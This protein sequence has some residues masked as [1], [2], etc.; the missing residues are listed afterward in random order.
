M[1]VERR[2]GLQ[3]VERLLKQGKLQAALGELRKVS[4]NAPNDLLTLNRL[5]D[6]LARQ[7]R[8][9]EAVAYYNK[10][11]AQFAGGGFVPKA[12]AIHKKILRLDPQNLESI[13]RLGELYIQQNLHGEARNY[14]LHAANQYLQSQQF[15][16]ARRIY[17][18]LVEV[19]PTD[20]R[21]RVRLAEAS[22]A[23]GNPRAAC[24]ALTD[25][26]RSLLDSGKAQEAEKLY[27]RAAELMPGSHVPLLGVASCLSEQG[28]AADGLALLEKAAGEANASPALVGDLVLRYD[29][30]GR[31]EEALALLLKLPVFEVPQ[32][33]WQ[34]LFGKYLIRGQVDRL[35]QRLDP[36]FQAAVPANDPQPLAQLLEQL[37]ELEAEGHVPALQRLLELQRRRHE[38]Q[39]TVQAL[40]WLVRA[41]QARSMHDEASLMLDEL[42]E[43]APDSPLVSTDPEVLRAYEERAAASASSSAPA[44]VV[45][46]V[47]SEAEAPAVPL[48]RADEEF[49][50]GRMT[51]AEVLEKYGLRPQALEQLQEVVSRFPGHVRAQEMRLKMLRSG[52]DKQ[53]LSGALVQFALALRADGDVQGARH[54][55]EEAGS[56]VTLDATTRSTLE[57]LKLVEPAARPAVAAAA[58]AVAAPEMV[59]GL[60]EPPSARPAPRERA[61]LVDDGDADVEIIEIDDEADVDAAAEAEE[62]EPVVAA[63]TATP[64]RPSSRRPTRVPSPDM[65]EEIERY[66]T[67]GDTQAALGRIDALR[68]L[69]YASPELDALAGRVSRAAPPAAAPIVPPATAT[70]Q[71]PEIEDPSA[72]LGLDDDD[73]LRAI[74][75]ALEHELFDGGSEPIVPEEDPEQS[76]DEIFATFKAQVQ[77]EVD[78]DDYRTHYDLGIAYKEMGLVDEAISEFEIASKCTS[79]Y[80]EACVMVALCHRERVDMAAAARWYRQALEAPGGEPEMLNRVRYELA[81]VLLE[82]GDGAG[83]LGLFRDVLQADPAYRDVRGRVTQLEADLR[84]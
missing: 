10:I 4:E 47:S 14:L 64:E 77:Q 2:K 63:R 70:A 17:E 27:R 48:N 3:T 53:R 38:T 61:V 32:H 13:V 8:N 29:A 59:V 7:G 67:T 11:A 43:L 76:L 57:Q 41:Y 65:L 46:D 79:L 36:V 34:G 18:R 73:D 44:P 26:G 56:L 49:V 78:S 74:T 40:E 30:V 54:A 16:R 60:E 50:A 33:V 20:F 68:L 24:D 28:R 39:G 71:E 83:A 58:A 69:G 21:H 22:A 84:S 19:D 72:A 42:R 55:A 37:G 62:R 25:L 81:E 35:W 75:E 1:T 5:G 15:E 80:R 31:T 23:A 52:A 45:V 82:A 6:L 12:I 51:Q 9:A 66:A